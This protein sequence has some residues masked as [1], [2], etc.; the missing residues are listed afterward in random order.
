MQIRSSLLKPISRRA[1]RAVPS[2]VYSFQLPGGK[3]N[4]GVTASQP[5]TP[6]LSWEL[7]G[8]KPPCSSCTELRQGPQDLPTG[9]W[10]MVAWDGHH[11]MPSRE[12]QG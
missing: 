8:V 3:P 5:Q 2:A 4:H 9:A 1:E 10:V 6:G 12:A 11:F 7:L